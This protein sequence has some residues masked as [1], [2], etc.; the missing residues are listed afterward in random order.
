MS[1]QKVSDIT[2]ENVAEHCKL[3]YAELDQDQQDHLE[4]CLKAAKAYIKSWTY[5][6]DTELD[7]YYELVMLV[8]W[9]SQNY[10]DNPALIINGL[11]LNPMAQSILKL[12][13]PVYDFDKDDKDDK[14]D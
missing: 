8:F 4:H 9:I 2:A 10:Y 12:H 11:Q 5:Y 3:N 6:D 14:D 7:K 13:Q 1:A